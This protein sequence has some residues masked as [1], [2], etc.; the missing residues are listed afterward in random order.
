MFFHDTDFFAHH[1]L[2]V[3]DVA[4][5]AKSAFYRNR[6]LNKHYKWVT[7]QSAELPLAT[8][9]LEKKNTIVAVCESRILYVDPETGAAKE[10]AKYETPL[11]G[12]SAPH[13]VQVK[14]NTITLCWP[15]FSLKGDLS[16]PKL[17]WTC[18][19]PR[20]DF[21]ERSLLASDGAR[22][23]YIDG[24]CVYMD[25]GNVPAELGPQPPACFAEYFG[26]FRQSERALLLGD[27]YV[28]VGSRMVAAFSLSTRRWERIGITTG[29]DRQCLVVGST[30][31]YRDQAYTF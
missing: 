19:T 4:G 24:S 10:G 31:F 2:R 29:P 12:G 9:Y 25:E 18:T 8:V 30:L 23:V 7:L 11:A 14:D 28:L 6:V 5:G 1:V 26:D 17:Q 15:R 16:C 27:H 20:R 13:A 21:V 22:L 3:G